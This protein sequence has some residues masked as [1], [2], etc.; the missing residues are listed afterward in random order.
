MLALLCPDDHAAVASVTALMAKREPLHDVAVHVVVGGKPRLWSVT[1][2]PV[3]DHDGR[4]AGYRGVG[5]DVTERWRAEQAEAENRAK[6][7]FLAMMSHEIRTPMNGVLGLANMLL[8][9]E[10]DPEQHHAVTTIRDSGD[11]LQRI[12]NDILDLSK[13]EAGRF[14]FEMV[15]FSPATLIECGVRGGRSDGEE[16]GPHRRDRY[17]DRICREALNGDAA[18]IRQVL[19]NLASN[20][21]KFTERGR[22]AIKV[23]LHATSRT[24]A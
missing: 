9:T 19:L 24:T 1:A 6:S 12:L 5:R 7:E 16:Q 22:V 17:R 8:E 14:Q 11:N 4:F 18:R 23:L 20:A 21:V 15:D 10:L 2:K 3:L 13:L